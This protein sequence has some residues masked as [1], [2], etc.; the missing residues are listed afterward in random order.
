MKLYEMTNC[1]KYGF[2][3]IHIFPHKNRIEDSVVIQ[4]NMGQRKRTF[5]H[6]LCSALLTPSNAVIS[7]N[8]LVL[9]FCEKTQFPFI[10]FLLLSLKYL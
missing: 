1:V 5:C 3:P 6:V 9:K 4:E 10:N 2:S 8:L 7:P